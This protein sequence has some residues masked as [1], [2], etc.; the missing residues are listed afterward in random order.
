MVWIQ[1]TYRRLEE[2]MMH[3]KG[4][5]HTKKTIVLV[6][7]VILSIQILSI[8]STAPSRI[9]KDV[10][11]STLQK[12]LHNA[13]FE[14]NFDII[15]QMKKPI[16]G[17]DLSIFK[18]LGFQT[19]QRFSAI[20]GIRLIG[21]KS[22]ILSLSTYKE[23]EWMEYDYKIQFY[24]EV[25]TTTINATRVWEHMVLSPGGNELGKI[26]G[27][28]VT[29]AVVD[30]G[31]DATHPDLDYHEKTIMNL[32]SDF[33]LYGDGIWQD[34]PNTD[35]GFGHGTHCAGTIAGN[36]D[37]SGEARRGVAPGAN[38]IGLGTGDALLFNVLGGLNWVYENSRPNANP[39]NIR[40][41]SN[42]WGPGSE[43][44]ESNSESDAIIQ[45]TN[46]LAYENNVLCVFAAGNDGGDGSERRTSRYSNNPVAIGVAAAWRDGM[47][48]ADFSSRGKK[49]ELDTYPDIAAPG[50]NIWS[51]AARRTV[52]GATNELEN[53]Y[54]LAI[55][56]T[57]MATPHVSGTVALM[58]QAAPSLRMSEMHED[59]TPEESN[60]QVNMT[61]KQIHEVEWILK[62]T[63][64]H[65]SPTPDNALPQENETGMYDKPLDY[66]QG[67]GVIDAEKAVGVALTLQELRKTNDEATVQDALDSYF[68]IISEK[69]VSERTNTLMTSW[70]GEWSRYHNTEAGMIF[71]TNQTRQILA[72]QNATKMVLDLSYTAI[73]SNNFQV[74]DLT[75]AVDYDRDGN[76]DYT[77]SLSLNPN[78]QKHE[79][80]DLISGEFSSHRGEYW[81]FDVLGQGFGGI[82]SPIHKEP[83]ELRSEY[84]YTVSFAFDLNEGE[85][86]YV[87]P[88]GINSGIGRLDFG[89]P[90]EYS[91]GT[92][93]MNIGTY[94]LNN[95][96]QIEEPEKE[97]IDQDLGWLIFFII[98]VISLLILT[99]IYITKFRNKSK[100]GP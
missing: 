85:T 92:L 8:S 22:A 90:M 11:N 57:S 55:S 93:N 37:A 72:P 60:E 45:V 65:I 43:E 18:V 15:I 73:D 42:S 44:E 1:F 25:S 23:V 52:I 27:S 28:G 12:K 89:E 100:K 51:A 47:G 67:Y 2:K 78:G 69:Q 62:A 10:I 96:G 63:A 82:W 50:V 40:A 35:N 6:L 49:G 41:V 13:D 48:M 5:L 17:H 7:L 91:G 84:D 14:D 76:F 94:D 71:E 24:Q 86:A 64:K 39:H 32:K 38:L 16:D 46:K 36:G 9:N 77:G 88:G 33:G 95:I 58:F 20:N 75:F 80:M 54:Y 29:V 87:D 61:E 79:E 34:M 97:I 59:Y 83:E 21:T 56:G 68:G 81:H 3:K 19:L 26:D 99:Y 31:I 30:T 4:I 74:V 53:A 70:R 66:I 98:A